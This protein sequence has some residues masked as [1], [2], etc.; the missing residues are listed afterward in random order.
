MLL[1]RH[2]KSVSTDFEE[3]QWRSHH[4]QRVWD[5]KQFESLFLTASSGSRESVEAFHQIETEILMEKNGEQGFL[6]AVD[7]LWHL[8]RKLEP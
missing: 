2:R 1:L 8:G 3:R 4:K 7:G 5:F 6:K